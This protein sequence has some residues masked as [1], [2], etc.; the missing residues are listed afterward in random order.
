LDRFSIVIT[1]GGG[2]QGDAIGFRYWNNPGPWTNFNGI[3]LGNS[4]MRINRFGCSNND[5]LDTNEAERGV[6]ERRQVITAGGGP[7]GDAIGFRYWNN[8]G[9]W[10]NFNG[11]TGPNEDQPIRMQ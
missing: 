9:P 10:T 11:I 1:A 5:S 4:T 3:S 2:P 6:D 7:Q 8:P